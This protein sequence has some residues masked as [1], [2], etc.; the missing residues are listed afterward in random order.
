ME[1]G[2]SEGGG[3]EERKMTSQDDKTSE[4]SDT[5][6]AAEDSGATAPMREVRLQA[7]HRNSVV[8]LSLCDIHCTVYFA[9]LKEHSGAVIIFSCTLRCRLTTIAV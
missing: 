7:L 1:G 9:S 2:G 6:D 3:E 5:T 8:T 4:P